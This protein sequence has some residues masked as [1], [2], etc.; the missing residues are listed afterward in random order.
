MSGAA[1]EKH[2]Q[3][4]WTWLSGLMARR[5]R[6]ACYHVRRINLARGLVTSSSTTYIVGKH[7]THHL[8]DLRNNSQSWALREE[9]RTRRCALQCPVKRRADRRMQGSSHGCL[10]SVVVTGRQG[11]SGVGRAEYTGEGLQELQERTG[12][13]RTRPDTTGHDRTRQECSRVQAGD[14]TGM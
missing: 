9:Y 8:T 4:L 6:P 10:M 7:Y 1:F 13:D 11:G 12:H 3:C 5:R 14:R 2:G